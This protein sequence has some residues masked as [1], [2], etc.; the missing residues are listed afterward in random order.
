MTAA[1]NMHSRRWQLHLLRCNLRREVDIDPEFA[2]LRFAADVNETAFW[3]HRRRRI[4]RALMC[5]LLPSRARVALEP[6]AAEAILSRIYRKKCRDATREASDK[7]LE[8]DFGL[9]M[10]RSPSPSS[11]FC[12]T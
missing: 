2:A 8:L 4:I 9:E 12:Q 5:I 1:C 3:K 10:P 7:F 6:A 11:S